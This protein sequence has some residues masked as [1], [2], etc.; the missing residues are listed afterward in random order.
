MQIDRSGTQRTET[1]TVEEERPA[2]P[3]FADPGE[4]QHE[5][6]EIETSAADPS[7]R[8]E[9]KVVADSRAEFPDESIGQRFEGPYD[10]GAPFRA[11]HDGGGRRAAM[12]GGK[13]R[14]AALALAGAGDGVI[15][16][17]RMRHR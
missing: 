5:F 10:A 8:N 6:A 1:A 4:Q 13:W 3:D 2:A 14:M 16:V 9:K 12:P 11:V 15:A 17:R 7:V